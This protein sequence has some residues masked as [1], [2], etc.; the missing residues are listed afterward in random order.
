M[1]LRSDVVATT[2]DANEKEKRPSKPSSKSEPVVVVKAKE[3]PAAA[4]PAKKS[5]AESSAPRYFEFVEG[6]SSKFWEVSTDGNDLTTRWG[7]IGS[8]GQSK[9]KTFASPE[10]ANAERDALIKS[11]LDGGY[12]EIEE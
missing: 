12:E 9:T 7:R 4:A 3:K 6:N 2:S 8:D 1:G 10:K 11:K 5:T